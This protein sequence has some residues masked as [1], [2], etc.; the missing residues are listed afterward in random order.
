MKVA[1]IIWGS[2]SEG[3]SQKQAFN[4]AKNLKEKNIDINVY[5]IFGNK[6][7]PYKEILNNIKQ[8]NL[9]ECY[10]SDEENKIMFPNK[11]LK[12]NKFLKLLYFNSRINKFS[13]KLAEMIDQDT[14]ILNVHDRF[15]YRVSYYYKKRNKKNHSI[16]M[17]NDI[18]SYRWNSER[19]E[20]L[21]NNFIDRLF[22]FFLDLYEKKFI[23]K[24]NIVT[25]LDNI[26]KLALKKYFNINSDIV[27]S[28]VD[29]HYF[30]PDSNLYNKKQNSN[31]KILMT[32]IL[33][34]HRRFEDAIL[35]INILKKEKINISLN[36]IGDY[37]NSTSYKKYLDEII[38][39]NKLQKNVNFLGSV[40]ED[41]LLKNYREHDIFIFPNHMQTWGLVVFEAMACGLPTLVSKTTGASEVLTDKINSLLVN[42]KNPQ[43][44]AEKINELIHDNELYIK[45]QRNGLDFIKDNISWDKY[46]SSM[47]EKMKIFCNKL[48]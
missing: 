11:I 23:K 20:Q 36:I 14:D 28:G 33:A 47:L 38:E 3:G 9:F 37:K 16:W 5:S 35:A 1:I 12:N 40:N 15:V 13:K 10:S 18:P 24:Q 7:N 6:D 43:E 25:V 42:P 8:T 39:K 26:N 48:V 22:R 29:N 31:I 46:G 27:R 19:F 44:I 17:A 2:Y 41:K 34:P 45:I 4:L 21:N 32:G 30:T